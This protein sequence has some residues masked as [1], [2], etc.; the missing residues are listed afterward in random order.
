MN[1]FV[2]NSVFS[3]LQQ[4]GISLENDKQKSIVQF[5]KFGLIGVTNTLL[6]YAINVAVLLLL[7]DRNLSWDYVPGNVISFVISVAWSFYWNNRYV[8]S[9]G[10]NSNWPQKLLKSYLS[11]GF[12]GIILS[13]GLSYIWINLLGVSKYIAPII[14]L[15]I[16]VPLNFIIHKIWVYH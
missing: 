1:D 13:N 15:I 7:K 16:S 8:F 2:E 6:S 12:T 14:N 3:L 10:D 9:N 4:F 11:Y 5:I